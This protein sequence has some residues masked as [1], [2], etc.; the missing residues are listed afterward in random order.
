MRWDSLKV[1][2]TFSIIQRWIT[3]YNSHKLYDCQ[4]QPRSS[5]PL[6]RVGSHCNLEPLQH[7][8]ELVNMIHPYFGR[9]ISS[10]TWRSINI[11]S[12]FYLLQLSFL[13]RSSQQISEIFI[14]IY[15]H[16]MIITYTE[17]KKDKYHSFLFLASS[18]LTW[19][20][21]WYGPYGY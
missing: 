20:I 17:I 2:I 6:E 3:I 16:D 21:S 9:D 18:F 14:K 12:N 4:F 10:V 5:S 1:S 19:A 7:V 8:E 15:W 13:T 11:N